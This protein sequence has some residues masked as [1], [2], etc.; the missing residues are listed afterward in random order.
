MLQLSKGDRPA[1]KHWRAPWPLFISPTQTFPASWLSYFL[2]STQ[3]R[4]TSCQL[5]SRAMPTQPMSTENSKAGAHA[6]NPPLRENQHRLPLWTE[7]KFP[8]ALN[9]PG[10][11][12]TCRRSRHHAA[13]QHCCCRCCCLCVLLSTQGHNSHRCCH[14]CYCCCSGCYSYCC[15]CCQ[16]GLQCLDPL[17]LLLLSL[18]GCP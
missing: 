9:P 7:N 8:S 3:V 4:C 16:M 2:K 17:P 1:C 18:A 12:G 13:L 14:Y 11:L 10:H 6:L 15:C 5:P